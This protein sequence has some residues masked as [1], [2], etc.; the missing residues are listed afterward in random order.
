MSII[1]LLLGIIAIVCAFVIDKP[2][3]AMY[4]KWI[5]LLGIFLIAWGILDLVIAL[6]ITLIAFLLFHFNVIKL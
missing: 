6:V 4:R 5:V 2:Q 3:V 1:L